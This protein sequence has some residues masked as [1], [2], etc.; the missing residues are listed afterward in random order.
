MY[1]SRN[2]WDQDVCLS[3]RLIARVARLE[4][5]CRISVRNGVGRGKDFA[6][7]PA[8]LAGPGHAI[9]APPRRFFWGPAG[10]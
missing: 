1:N 9:R 2:Y 8:L 7:R 6:P 4:S 5:E 10:Y 3:P